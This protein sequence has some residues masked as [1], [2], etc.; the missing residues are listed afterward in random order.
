MWVFRDG[1]IDGDGDRVLV[2]VLMMVGRDSLGTVSRGDGW[3]GWPCTDVGD[4][5]GVEDAPKVAVIPFF[6][7][8]LSSF[9]PFFFLRSFL[10]L[11][12]FPHTLQKW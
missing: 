5:D 8:F 4:G 7:S 11:P 6:L 9:L 12:S 10:P 3:W 1:V 2:M